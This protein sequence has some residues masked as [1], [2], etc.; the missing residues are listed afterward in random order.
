MFSLKSL[1]VLL[2]CVL[3]LIPLQQANAA[4]VLVF[5]DSLS[6]AYGLRR[7]DGWVYLLQQQLPGHDFINASISGETTGNGLARLPSLLEQHKPDVLV[8][9]LGANDGLRGFP[10]STVRDNLQAMIDLGRAAGCR[11]L[12]LG[13]QIPPNYGSR[14]AKQFAEIFPQLAEKNRIEVVPFFLQAIAG[15]AVHFQA[16][17]IHPTAAAQPKILATV[18]PAIEPL[19]GP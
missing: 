17:T 13:I 1:V 14:Y 7:E 8:I 5:G 2:V 6:A 4:S 9:E 11:I 12:L 15:D 10:L 3:S 18:R 16:D 19:L